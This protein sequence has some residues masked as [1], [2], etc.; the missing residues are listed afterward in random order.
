MARV[1]LCSW[2]RTAPVILPTVFIEPPA[3]PL[4][5]LLA[6]LDRPFPKS[7][8]LVKRAEPGS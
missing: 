6:P 2:A 5:R 1:P 3:T 8:G 7:A 4:S